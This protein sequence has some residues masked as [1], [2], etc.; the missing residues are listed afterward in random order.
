MSVTYEL[1]I[2]AVAA[3]IVIIGMVVGNGLSEGR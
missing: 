3:G 1:I 2:L